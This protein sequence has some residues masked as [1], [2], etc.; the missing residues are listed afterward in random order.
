MD[1]AVALAALGILGGAVTGFVWVAKFALKE[2]SKDLKAHTA[3]AIRQQQASVQQKE[4]SLRSAQASEKL[5]RTV[6]KVGKQAELT[7]KNSEQLLTFMKNLNGK[8]AKATI[9]T[10][11]EQNV[12]HQTVNKQD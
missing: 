3:A 2:L 4:A 6:A 10:V 9:Q 7:G 5:E 11:K 12:E 1:N 8:L